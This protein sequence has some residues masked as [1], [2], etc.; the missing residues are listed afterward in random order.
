[1]KLK[2]VRNYSNEIG[3]TTTWVYQLIKDGKLKSKKIDGVTFII[4]ETETKRIN[5]END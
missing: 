4:A 3:K 5:P 2:T 1:M